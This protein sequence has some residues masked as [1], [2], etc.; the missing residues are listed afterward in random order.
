MLTC[1]SSCITFSTAGPFK[2]PGAE[3]V[4]LTPT[5][6]AARRPYAIFTIIAVFRLMSRCRLLAERKDVICSNILSCTLGV[7]RG[8]HIANNCRAAFTT[9]VAGGS[10]SSVASVN[11]LMYNDKESCSRALHMGERS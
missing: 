2:L 11:G 9:S 10:G 1:N 7:C 6:S 4:S 3:C 5:F 8:R